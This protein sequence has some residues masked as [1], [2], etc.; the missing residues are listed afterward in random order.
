M[1]KGTYYVG[2][3]CYIFDK[4]WDKILTE[5]GCFSG[6]DEYTLFGEQCAIGGTAYG[7][8]CYMDNFGQQYWV[9]AG[10]IGILPISLINI[11]NKLSIEEIRKSEGMHI[12][13]C[14]TDF[15]VSIKNGIFQFGSIIIDTARI[16]EEQEDEDY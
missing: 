16:D 13:E 10:L 1:K 7:D 9:D 12:I 2:D 5:T 3:P 6:D 8:G 15:K 4:S 14:D 11:D